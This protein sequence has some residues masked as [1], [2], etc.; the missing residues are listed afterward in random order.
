MIAP[1]RNSKNQFLSEAEHDKWQVAFR[2]SMYDD[3]S[4]E[5]QKFIRERNPPYIDP[6]ILAAHE[7]S[8]LKERVSTGNKVNRPR[9]PLPPVENNRPVPLF[10]KRSTHNKYMI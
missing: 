10:T 4:P 2:L 6:K 5:D 1:G 8:R 3:L 7:Q 9:E